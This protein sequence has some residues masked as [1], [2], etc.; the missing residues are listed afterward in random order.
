MPRKIQILCALVMLVALL[1]LLARGGGVVVVQASSAAPLCPESVNYSHPQFVCPSAVLARRNVMRGDHALA[2]AALGGAGA[3]MSQF[4]EDWFLYTEFFHAPRYVR[5]ANCTFIELGGYDGRSGSNSHFYDRQLGWRGLLLEASTPN[6]ALLEK[7][8]LS[9]RVATIHGAVC[10]DEE[11]LLTLWGGAS[12]TANNQR[13]ANGLF[14]ADQETLA[15]CLPM[16][17]YVQMTERR[18]GARVARIDYFSMDVEGQE[19]EIIRSHDWARY[20]VFVV[21]I[22]VAVQPLLSGTAAY[23]HEKRCG[24]Y[25]RGLCRWPFYD[26]YAPPVKSDAAAVHF[27]RNNE[28]WVNPALLE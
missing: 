16:A 15:V 1:V 3:F 6:Y 28:I 23:Q 25:Q 19:L 21:S 24:L 11:R 18:L 17:S 9:P 13:E 4:W 20:P 22:E 2:Y 10:A 27:S 12:L 5:C 7:E 26:D 8:R 14:H